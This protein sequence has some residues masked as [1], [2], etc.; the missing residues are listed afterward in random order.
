M[1]ELPDATAFGFAVH[2]SLFQLVWAVKR[3]RRGEEWRAVDDLNG[4]AARQGVEI[5]SGDFVIFR[6]GQL[7]RC[8]T[9]GQWGSYAGGDAPGLAFE[10]CHWIRQKDIAAICADTWGCEVRPNH[11]EVNQP[12]HW[13]VIPAIGITMGEMFYL[14]DLAEDCVA[15]GRYEFFFCAPPLVI[16]V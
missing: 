3:W 7:E 10:T 2:T 12:W 11:A 5:R 8:L 14:K 6:T 15:D 13:V 9:E 16:T 4:C 1:P